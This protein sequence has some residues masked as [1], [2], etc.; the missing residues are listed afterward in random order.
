MDE[1]KRYKLFKLFLIFTILNILGIILY[2]NLEKTNWVRRKPEFYIEG[3]KIKDN[4][5]N[6][7]LNDNKDRESESIS[8]TDSKKNKAIKTDE[9]K[10]LIIGDSNAYLMSKNKDYYKK[11]YEVPVYWLAE[12]GAKA[13]F[14]SKQ[15]DVTVGQFMPQYVEN[16]LTKNMQVSLLNEIKEKDI[17][18]VA[19]M[20]GVNSLEESS[21]KNLSKRL[22]TLSKN[23]N[24]R[25]YYVAL[26]PYVDKSEYKIKN[27]DIINFNRLMKENLSESKIAY[28]DSYSMVTSLEGYENETTD[29]LHYSGVIYD[30]ILDKIMDN[31]MQNNKK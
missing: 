30:K 15:L 26:L 3:I 29:G 20:L 23:A 4:V 14:I 25:V 16:S 9:M 27:N 31:I 2:E 5:E 11:K 17:T 24:V 10:V 19:V 13:D 21:A 12:S 6:E 18:D 28:I 7:K 22:I 8:E 1:N